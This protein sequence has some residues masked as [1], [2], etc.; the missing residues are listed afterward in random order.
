MF[1]LL[2]KRVQMKKMFGIFLCHHKGGG[3]VLARFI[4]LAMRR[5]T[6]AE[7]FL[8]SDNLEDLDVLFDIVRTQVQNHVVLLTSELLKRIWCAGEI[9]TAVANNVPIVPVACD[10]YVS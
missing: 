9:V 10:D 2:G 3:G 5:S 6:N 7:I 8:D 1:S 4:K